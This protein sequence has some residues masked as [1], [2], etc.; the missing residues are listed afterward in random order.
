[1]KRLALFLMIFIVST[2]ALGLAEESKLKPQTVCPVMGGKID[3][4]VYADY[5]GQRIYFCCP[6]CVESFFNEP[7]KYMNKLHENKVLLESIQEYCPVMTGHTI[8]CFINKDIHTDYKGRRVYFC[9]DECRRSFLKAPD[10]YLE[11]LR[12]GSP[13]K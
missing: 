3:K 9:S 8:P 11:Y 7:E 13:P 6:S 10:K 2:S 5:Q 1:M 4:N 12:D